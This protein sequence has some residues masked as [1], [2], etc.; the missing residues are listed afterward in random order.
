[1]ALTGLLAGRIIKIMPVEQ[2]KYGRIVALV[3]AD[4]TLAN[5]AMVANGYAWVFPKYCTQLYCNKWNEDEIR[6][7]AA[8]KGIWET[9]QIAPWDWRE[10]KKKLKGRP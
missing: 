5:Q 7:R 6:A 9:Q 1:M 10:K 4:D 3:Y 8:C 2:D